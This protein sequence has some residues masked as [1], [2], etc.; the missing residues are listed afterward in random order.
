MQRIISRKAQRA[1][2]FRASCCY[3][4]AMKRKS[5]CVCPSPTGPLGGVRTALVI[6]F[7]NKTMEILFSHWKIPTE[8]FCSGRGGSIYRSFEMDRYT[9]RTKVLVLVMDPIKLPDK[10]NAKDL[11]K[12]MLT[13]WSIPV[14]RIMLLTKRKS[15]SNCVRRWNRKT[16]IC[17]Q[18]AFTHATEEFT[19]FYQ[20]RRQTNRFPQALRLCYSSE[21]SCRWRSKT[22][23]YYSWSRGVHSSTDG[24]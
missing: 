21:S 15:W 10:V 4:C 23:R 6:S 7:T 1:Q 13:D 11:Y 24:W 19:H 17:L 3:L 12:S 16:N 20:K 8:S 22:D 2:S 5:E 9:S 18:R 14:M